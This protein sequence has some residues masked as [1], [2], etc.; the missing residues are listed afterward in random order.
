MSE[1]NPNLDGVNGELPRGAMLRAVADG[2]TPTPAGL[3]SDDEARV[4]FE[5]GLRDCVGRSLGGTT[6]PA[7]LRARIEGMLGGGA[8]AGEHETDGGV[9]RTP[10][11]DTRRQS[12]WSGVA[13]LASVAAV[14]AICS[15]VVVMAVLQ[16]RGGGV[17]PADRQAAS[18][19]ATFVQT[20]HDKCSVENEHTKKK[21]TA[22]DSGSA[23]EMS[24]KILGGVP[25]IVDNGF[26]S[27]A[28]S[29]FEFAGLGGCGV[30]GR[31]PSV[32]IV[33]RSLDGGNRA[34][35]LF[36]QSNGD[37]HV[38]ESRCATVREGLADGR[39]MV[40]WETG[41]FQHYLFSAHS[42]DLRVLRKALGAPSRECQMSRC[43]R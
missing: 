15:T 9:V 40:V 32:H 2:E 7:E 8:G 11:G 4:G 38:T 12:F 22:R 34:A 26:A 16:S 27:L 35:S 28:G 3:G 18:M 24:R 19:L 30:P 1:Q 31:G 14:L 21:F 37:W 5:R 33:F 13:G 10:L 25:P 17:A 23:E 39:T 41:G 43:E 29:G 20:A 42:G 6:A 36:I